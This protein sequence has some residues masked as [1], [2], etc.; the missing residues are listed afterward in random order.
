MA[1]SKKIRILGKKGIDLIQQLLQ[2]VD[3]KQGEPT[4]CCEVGSRSST[5]CKEGATDNS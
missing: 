3:M 2:G 4:A 1:T 5:V